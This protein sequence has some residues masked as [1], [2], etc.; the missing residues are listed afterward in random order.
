MENELPENVVIDGTVC[1][2]VQVK[3]TKINYIA[4]LIFFQ[5]SV[6][7]KM[8]LVMFGNWLNLL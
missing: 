5:G 3:L 6:H 4:N 1:S 2:W 7:L 8:Y